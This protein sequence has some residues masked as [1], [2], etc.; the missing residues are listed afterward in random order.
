[1]HLVNRAGA[2]SKGA[3]RAW[4]ENFARC[5][6]LRP[7]AG[8][9]AC[10]AK[11]EERDVQGT[12]AVVRHMDDDRHA[13]GQHELAG[14]FFQGRAVGKA[15]IV[16]DETLELERNAAA[17]EFSHAAALRN[18][19]SKARSVGKLNAQVVAGLNRKGSGEGLTGSAA[20]PECV[21]TL[22]DHKVGGR[23]HRLRNGV[24]ACVQRPRVVR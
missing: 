20:N 18:R 11:A 4:L 5:A 1:M 10:W 22:G 16:E 6:R 17:G 24:D 15:A 19:D 9:G 2:A 13:S 12:V 8:N 14:D 21:V 3:R 23:A 7:Q